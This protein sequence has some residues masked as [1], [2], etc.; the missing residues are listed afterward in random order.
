MKGIFKKKKTNKILDAEYR[1]F[2]LTL[3]D[4]LNMGDYNL[5]WYQKLYICFKNSKL[6]KWVDT[7]R[8]KIKYNNYNVSNFVYGCDGFEEDSYFYCD[9]CEY[10]FTDDEVN[11][12]LETCPNCDY[13]LINIVES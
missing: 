8:A 4:M 7:W 2:K 1:I 9:N 12:K 3:L 10:K 6:I 11:E 13:L 5:H